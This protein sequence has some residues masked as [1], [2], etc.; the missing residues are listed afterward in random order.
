[1]NAKYSAIKVQSLDTMVASA[2]ATWTTSWTDSHYSESG[3]T[4]INT[5]P[6]SNRAVDDKDEMRAYH[7][8]SS[9][10]KEVLVGI[11]LVI[12]CQ[13]T[14][15][16]QCNNVDEGET[17]KLGKH[18]IENGHDRA[19]VDNEGQQ[20]NDIEDNETLAELA[21][22]KKANNKKHASIAP[23]WRRTSKRVE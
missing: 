6:S 16:R 9:L 8:F 4:L 19:S 2:T 15:W 1:M 23:M 20:D 14:R 7:R 21:R 3:E 17:D 22:K 12:Y 18:R 10:M 5:K 13:A 11:A